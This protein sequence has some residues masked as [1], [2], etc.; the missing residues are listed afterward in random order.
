MLKV[1]V[2]GGI[3]SGKSSVCKIFECLGVPVFR[4]DDEGRRLLSEDADVQ[5]KVVDLFGN[6]VLISGKLDRKK[7]ASVVFND[8]KKLVQLNSVIHPAVRNSFL[9]WL[10]G[11]STN[12]IIEEAAIL[13]ESGAYKN[14]DTVIVVSAPEYVR[15]DRV[16]RRD[17]T[18]EQE[19]KLRMKNQ[20]SEE[21]RVK[22]ASHVIVNDGTAM[23]IPA[24][25]D[26]HK[27]LLKT[28]KG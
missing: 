3:G 12:M 25:L 4:A 21:D 27:S 24:V 13:F 6:S 7:I 26:L 5:K 18:T 8:E 9:N 14:M 17:N 1:G 11:Q 10:N 15:I 19:V 2:T 28:K 23:L 20:L 22:R 16:M